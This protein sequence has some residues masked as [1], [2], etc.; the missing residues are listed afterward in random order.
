MALTDDHAV[1]RGAASGWRAARAMTSLLHRLA[2]ARLDPA[3]RRAIVQVARTPGCWW[4]ATTT[5]P[6]P[7]SSR[8]RGGVPAAGDGGRAAVARH[9]AGDDRGG[10]L[11]PRAARAGGAVPAARRSASSRQSWHGV[12]CWAS[13]THWPSLRRRCAQ[14]LGYELRALVG[15]ARG[16]LLEEKPPAWPSTC[17][18]P[19]LMWPGRCWTRSGGGRAP[20]TAYR[21]PRAMRCWS[22]R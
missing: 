11:R 18:R 21:S 17:A 22:C 12:R 10:D 2:P 13:C 19:R 15:D 16:V 7:R 3:L 14:A 1:A 9:P 6:W 4:R 8:I 20:G 5:G